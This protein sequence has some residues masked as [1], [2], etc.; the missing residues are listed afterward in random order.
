MLGQAIRYIPLASIAGILFITCWRMLDF[1]NIA[2]N[3][4]ATRGDALTLIVTFCATL[5]LNLEFAIYIGV[6]LSIGLYLARTANPFMRA[7]KPQTPGGTMEHDERDEPCPQMGIIGIDGSVFFGS[8]EFIRNDLTR[9][10]D[11]HPD[12]QNLLI[13]MHN[14]EVLDASGVTSLEAVHNILHKRGGRLS[15]AGL[16][17]MNT[18]VLNN[19]GLMSLIG[20]DYVRLHTANAMTSLF[21]TFSTKRCHHCPYAHFKE[22]RKLKRHGRILIQDEEKER[23]KQEKLNARRR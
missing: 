16:S 21:H 23:R 5:L 19:S 4:R 12:M 1:H 13:R 15:L 3:L 6:L 10:L 18:Q 14:V 8:A 22:C 9:Y 11:N 7:L 17:R 20:T 2:L